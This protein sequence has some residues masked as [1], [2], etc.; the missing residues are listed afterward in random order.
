MVTDTYRGRNRGHT[1]GFMGFIWGNMD[2]VYDPHYPNYRRMLDHWKWLLNVSRTWDGGF[3]VPESIIGQIYT[4]RGPVLSTGGMVQVF[5]MPNRL[6]RIHGCPRASSRSRTCRPTS[7][8]AW[9]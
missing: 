4:Y 6:L 3:L 7:P 5:A 8:A 2:G 9:R 1:G